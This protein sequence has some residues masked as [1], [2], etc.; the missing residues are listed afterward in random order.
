MVD[1][2][3]WWALNFTVKRVV[4]WMAQRTTAHA[5]LVLPLEQLILNA[6]EKAPSRER[7]ETDQRPKEDREKRKEKNSQSTQ[8]GEKL[9]KATF[10]TVDGP[11]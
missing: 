6:F 5:E 9:N 7:G 2:W 3:I 10:Q 1:F 8:T 4:E 11:E